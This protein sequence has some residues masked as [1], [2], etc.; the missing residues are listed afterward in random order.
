MRPR[1]NGCWLEP[2]EPRE[3]NNNYTEANAWQYT[4][5]VPHDLPA[6]IRLMGGI[7][8]FSSKLDSLFMANDKTTGRDQ[9][10]ISGL[11]GQ[12]AQGNEPSHH[13]AYLYNS[14]CKPWKTQELVH[15]ILSSFYKSSP[16]GLI[17]NEDCG[18]MSAWYVLSSMGFYTRA[19]TICYRG[20]LFFFGKHS[21][22][23]RKD[24][25]YPD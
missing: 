23:E 14:C 17:G 16:D 15:K 20:T 19:C 25:L 7:E 22:G 1:K 18:Q 13:I 2:F 12:Y 9:V 11:I 21:S 5:F 6:Y 3:V 10:D 8:K 4:F 24:F